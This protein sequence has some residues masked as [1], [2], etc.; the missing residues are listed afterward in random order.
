MFDWKKSLARL[1][2]ATVNQESLEDAAELMVSVSA[3]DSSYHAEC[4]ATL[5]GGIKACDSGDE[6]VISAIGRSGYTVSSLGEAKELLMEFLGIYEDSYH[7][8]V[9]K[10]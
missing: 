4:L 7:Q 2:A 5:R 8:A 10:K 1:F 3:R 6:D 9:G